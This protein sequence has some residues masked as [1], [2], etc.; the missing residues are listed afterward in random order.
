MLQNIKIQNYRGIKEL[1]I[2]DFK[3]INLIVGRNNSRKTSV[4]EAIFFLL[5]ANNPLLILE[6]ILRKNINDKTVQINTQDEKLWGKIR[7]LFNDLKISNPIKISS[8]Q[9]NKKCELEI[10]YSEEAKS[11]VAGSP[12]STLPKNLLSGYKNLEGKEIITGINN[13]SNNNVLAGANLVTDFAGG[14]SKLVHA[15]PK[16]SEEIHEN[17]SSFCSASI[18]N[19]NLILESLK[20]IEPNLLDIMTNE[21]MNCFIKEDIS[22]PI[23]FMGDGMR[24]F[25]NAITTI[26]SCKNSIVLFDEI[27][28]G[29]HWE[30][31][32]IMWKAIMMA[33]KVSNVQIFATTHSYDM[34]RS[35]KEAYYDPENKDILGDD[36]IRL[37]K[38]KTEDNDNL[39]IL[40][41]DSDMIKYAVT[42]EKEVR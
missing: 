11:F 42:E 6:I 13:S 18:N 25:L 32:K 28:E 4:L 20:Q 9:E 23:N 10:K 27:D 3:T 29:L 34:I 21:E 41:Y 24:S 35:L 36:Q 30:T 7:L 19:K 16:K 5:A 33:C 38:I 40:D 22:I 15:G 8:Q 26:H 1:E 39:K 2:K 37:Y 17:F 31:Q 14:Y 12:I